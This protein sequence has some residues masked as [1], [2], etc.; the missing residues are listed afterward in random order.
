MGLTNFHPE[1]NDPRGAATPGGPAHR[2][3][4]VDSTHPTQRIGPVERAAEM[5]RMA[6]EIED[7]RQKLMSAAKRADVLG[8]SAH[9]NILLS[10]A[11]LDDA[12]T[13]LTEWVSR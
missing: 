5:Q 7:A 13:A 11:A 3:H 10:V 1:S 9:T 12:R 4:P 2:R 6:E 8:V